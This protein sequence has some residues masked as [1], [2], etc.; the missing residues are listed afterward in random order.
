MTIDNT[1]DV[2]H[3]ADDDGSGDG[4][5]DASGQAQRRPDR[6]TGPDVIADYLKTLPGTPGV[7]ASSTELTL[8]LPY[9]DRAAV[10]QVFAD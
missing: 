1:S 6:R 5:G 3:G 2:P 10:E 4:S 8:V 7:P 9:N